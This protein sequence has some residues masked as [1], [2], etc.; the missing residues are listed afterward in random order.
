MATDELTFR[1]SGLPDFWAQATREVVTAN[2]TLLDAFEANASGEVVLHGW[3]PK[4]FDFMMKLLHYED[5][6]VDEF[7]DEFEAEVKDVWSIASFHEKYVRQAEVADDDTETREPGQLTVRMRQ[8][9]RRWWAENGEGFRG[10]D[11]EYLMKL[12]MPAFYIGDAQTFMSVTHDCFL[13]TNSKQASSMN[14]KMP[15][16]PDKGGKNMIDTEHPLLGK[17]AAARA[18]MI[19]KIEDALPYNERKDGLPRGDGGTSKQCEDPSWCPKLKS[20]A[21]YKALNATGCWPVREAME[22]HSVHS[23]LTILAVT[24]DYINYDKLHNV[25]DRTAARA[26]MPATQSATEDKRCSVCINAAVKAAF[27]RKVKSLVRTLLDD[28]KTWI[29][30]K[31]WRQPV[32]VDDSFAG[33]CLDCLIKTKFGCQDVDYWNHAR[34]FQYDHGCRVSHG[35]PTWYYSYLG[36]PEDMKQ[37]RKEKRAQM[38]RGG[39]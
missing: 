27:D 21:Y 22:D 3:S 30:N 20:A 7:F 18:N 6:E 8:W 23:L 29:N 33:L 1:I 35:Q 31:R 5:D 16:G 24:F 13:H 36:R 15:E 26:K 4:V 9:F 17:L 34:K 14:A 2:T 19:G 28:K 38:Q 25:P 37:Y 39:R 32:R 11:A 10:K 12:V